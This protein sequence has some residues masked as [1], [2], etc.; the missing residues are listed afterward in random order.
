MMIAL[1]CFDCVG[2]RDIYEPA[3]YCYDSDSNCDCCFV[4]VYVVQYQ[5]CSYFYGR[6]LSFCIGRTDC[7]LGIPFEYEAEYRCAVRGVISVI[8]GRDWFFCFTDVVEKSFEEKAVCC[9]SF[10]SSV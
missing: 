1:Y 8:L 7:D 3:V 10:A 6:W 5:P 4:G 9:S 2:C